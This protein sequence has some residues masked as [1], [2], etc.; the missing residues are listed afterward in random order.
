M[1]TAR[2][3]RALLVGVAAILIAGS[4]V[5]QPVAPE[6][7]LALAR[8]SDDDGA[9][10][11]ARDGNRN[12]IRE[13]LP[14]TEDIDAPGSEERRAALARRARRVAGVGKPSRPAP[15]P[16]GFAPTASAPL[17]L[18][19][20]NGNAEMIRIARLGRRGPQC[21]RRSRR[22]DVDGGGR[23]RRPGRGRRRCSSSAPTSTAASRDFETDRVDVRCPE[24]FQII[25]H[26]LIEAGAEVD[27]RTR[28]DEEPDWILPNSRPGFSF[29]IGIIR[30]GLPADRGMR[31]F[32]HG[33]M[34][35]LLYA[36]RKRQPG[37][38]RAPARRRRRHQRHRGQ[39]DRAVAD[40]DLQ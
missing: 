16:P 27:A 22:N 2:A 29:G 12:A 6:A 14:G 34:T 32:Q 28:V 26:A 31:P 38:R 35:P 40:G 24:G 18:A 15:T 19:A 33:G 21:A 10:D 4:A 20:T 39:F 5:S 36:A 13:L 1:A 25:A 8:G 37:G 11:A 3:A 30:G 7:R 9:A 23:Q 17:Y